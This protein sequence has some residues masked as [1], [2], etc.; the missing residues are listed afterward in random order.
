MILTKAS[1]VFMILV[2]N[3]CHTYFIV[4]NLIILIDSLPY[5][6]ADDFSLLQNFFMLPV[7]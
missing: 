5:C 1:S 4:I 7:S 2:Y 3:L 6:L